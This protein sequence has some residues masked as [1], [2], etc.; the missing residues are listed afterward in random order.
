MCKD[1]YQPVKSERKKVS[2]TFYGVGRLEAAFVR[3]LIEI[4]R[5]KKALECCAMSD[6]SSLSV[7]SSFLESSSLV[8]KNES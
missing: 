8:C 4:F 7:I 1:I 3:V 6:P 5:N 2:L